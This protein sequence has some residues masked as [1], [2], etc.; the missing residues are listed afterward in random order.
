[1]K[2]ELSLPTSTVNTVLKALELA[3]Q[4]IALADAEI[5]EQILDQ[6]NDE[7]DESVD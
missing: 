6:L 1:M 4:Q 7:D 2:I 5:R 3:S